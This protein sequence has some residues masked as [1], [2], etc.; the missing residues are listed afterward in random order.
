MGIYLF[1][2]TAQYSLEPG[3]V[4]IR[5]IDP[6]DMDNHY[7]T[8]WTSNYYQ[9]GDDPC[10]KTRKNTITKL[11]PFERIPIKAW[12][13]ICKNNQRLAI[14]QDVWI[15][16]DEGQKELMLK[17]VLKEG[18]CIRRLQKDPQSAFLTTVRELNVFE[19]TDRN[20]VYIFPL[21]HRNFVSN[22]DKLI[23]MRGIDEVIPPKKREVMNLLF[24]VNDDILTYADIFD[25][26]RR[27][28]GVDIQN[29]R[30]NLHPIPSIQIETDG[31]RNGNNAKLVESLEQ[32]LIKNSRGNINIHVDNFNDF[33][34]FNISFNDSSCL[35]G[36]VDYTEFTNRL[37]L[38]GVSID[39]MIINWGVWN[40]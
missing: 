25:A 32:S 20:D 17:S 6:P 2:K 22:D 35:S 23:F 40:E 1:S 5:R 37:K 21:V 38:N 11:K 19:E 3:N 28:N 14:V 36:E 39:T 24:E 34:I 31:F 15:G 7:N 29:L 18:V 33:A 30:F 12:H 26:G 16:D 13:V 9:Y 4:R 8:Y 10:L 27:I